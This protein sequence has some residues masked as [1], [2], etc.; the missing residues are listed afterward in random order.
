MHCQQGGQVRAS[1]GLLHAFRRLPSGFEL[2]LRSDSFPGGISLTG[3]G[4]RSDWCSS[5]VL[6][7][8][9]HRSDR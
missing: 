8:L 3:E 9:V 6:G 2:L 1:I 7:D 4:H 5:E